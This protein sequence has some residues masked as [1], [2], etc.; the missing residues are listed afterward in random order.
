VPEELAEFMAD[1]QV[2]VS[3]TSFGYVNGKPAWKRKPTWYCV[4]TEDH[5]IPPDAE[6]FWAKRMNATTTEI[7]GS[8][9][10]FISHPEKVAAV[11]KDAAK[12]A[13]N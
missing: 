8:H 9:V 1:S 12:N 11:I 13:L 3:V 2:P 6:R 7:K 10:I 4:A 5:T